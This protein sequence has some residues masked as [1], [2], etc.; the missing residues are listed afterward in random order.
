MRLG[1]QLSSTKF[2][3]KMHL[4]LPPII[5]QPTLFDYRSRVGL[6]CCCVATAALPAYVLV[7]LTLRGCVSAARRSHPAGGRRFQSG[8]KHP[9]MDEMQHTAHDHARSG[10]A[11]S[12]RAHASAPVVWTRLPAEA[13]PTGP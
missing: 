3:P 8:S 9:D 4:L 2:A 11:T 7:H 10:P 12:G 5:H 1:D 13:G 6:S